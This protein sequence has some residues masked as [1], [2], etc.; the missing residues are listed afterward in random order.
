MGMSQRRDPQTALGTKSKGFLVNRVVHR[1]KLS[2]AGAALA[3]TVVVLGGVVVVGSAIGATSSVVATTTVNLRSG[4]G[5]NYAIIGYLPAGATATATGSAVAG[6]SST[7]TT[8]TPVTYQGRSGYVATSYLR[9]VG[10]S[11]VSSSGGAVGTAVVNSDVNVRSGPGT[12]YT[13]V[14]GL[15]AGAEVETTGVTSGGWTQI[16]YGG[17]TRWVFGSFLGTSGTSSDTQTNG[18]IRTSYDLY[19][20][21]DGY[22]GATILA[23]VP[24]NSLLD[25]TGNT[26]ADYTQVVY[27]GKTGWVA[28][29]YTVAATA[30]PL[31]SSG[32]GSSSGGLTSSQQKLVDYAKAQVGDAYV[33]GAEGPSAFDCSGLTRAAYLTVGISLPHHSATQATLGTAVSRANLQPGDLIFWYS[34]VSHVSMY[35]GNGRMVH[36]RNTTV[37]VV[38]QSVDSYISAGGLYVGARRYLP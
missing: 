9:T 25:V 16:L 10:T 20:R 35:I 13:I 12:S 31:V 37:G 34:P 33:W 4:P 18:Q 1:L 3:S 14:G 30:A 22:L 28:S 29:R 15:S 27:Q 36:A 11:E 23:L 32:T 26:T 21:A 5:T 24:A 8:W 6:Q 2:V 17:T 7:G 38:E 19:L